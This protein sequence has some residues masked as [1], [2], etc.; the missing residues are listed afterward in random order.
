[1]IVFTKSG[2]LPEWNKY[3][4]LLE[5]SPNNADNPKTN[6]AVVAVEIVVDATSRTA[7]ARR[8]EPR[9]TAQQLTVIILFI[10]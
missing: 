9:T 5:S 3:K 10:I 8:V 7:N 2:I 4:G 6:M 1:L